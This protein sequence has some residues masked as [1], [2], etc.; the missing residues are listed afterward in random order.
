MM[1]KVPLKVTQLLLGT[2][3]RNYLKKIVLCSVRAVNCVSITN[4]RR[5]MQDT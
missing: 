3:T 5:S 2:V 1:L 4:A